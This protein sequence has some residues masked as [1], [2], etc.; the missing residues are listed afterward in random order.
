MAAAAAPA[1]ETH[2]PSGVTAAA[3]APRA[4]EAERHSKRHRI[5]SAREAVGEK[6]A[7]RM[8]K[9]RQA[10]NVMLD[11]AAYDPSLRFVLVAVAILVL[12]IV[13]F[14]LHGLIG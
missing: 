13:L 5:S 12:T 11:E 2:A 6:I 1:S 4:A 14:L 10:S 7:P 8:E 3:A 9:L